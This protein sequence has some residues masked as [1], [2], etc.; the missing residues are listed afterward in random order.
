MK[1]FNNFTASS[2]DQ[3]IFNLMNIQAFDAA[4]AVLKGVNVLLP[5]ERT[6]QIHVTDQYIIIQT[7]GSAKAMLYKAE[8]LLN[9]FGTV[10]LIKKVLTFESKMKQIMGDQSDMRTGFYSIAYGIKPLAEGNLETLVEGFVK[11]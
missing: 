5:I 1:E 6:D 4:D 10:E 8:E 11:S 9:V 2:F 7:M 3:A